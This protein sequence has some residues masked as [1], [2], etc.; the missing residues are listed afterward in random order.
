M[1]LLTSL[2]SLFSR[3]VMIPQKCCEGA[4]D[5]VTTLFRRITKYGEKSKSTHFSA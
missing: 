3:H 1:H 5:S 4:R 2:L